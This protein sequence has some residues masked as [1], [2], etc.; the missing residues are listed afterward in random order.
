LK[1]ENANYLP[2][3]MTEEERIAAEEAAS[4]G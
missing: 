3:E 4:K 1:F 2:K